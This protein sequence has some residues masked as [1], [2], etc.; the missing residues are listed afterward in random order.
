[1]DNNKKAEEFTQICSAF[2][3]T[4]HK[5]YAGMEDCGIML[6]AVN[7]TDTSSVKRQTMVL[8]DGA[9]LTYGLLH[10]CHDDESAVLELLKMAASVS[11]YGNLSHTLE[12]YINNNNGDKE[13]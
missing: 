9:A 2:C 10:A 8:G 4:M 6:I 5:K 13:V 7:A 12:R 1:M 3:E 11:K